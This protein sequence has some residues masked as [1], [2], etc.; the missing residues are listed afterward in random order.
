MWGYGLLGV[1]TWLMSGYYQGKN[2]L[3]RTLLIANGVLSLLSALWTIIDVN[4]VMTTRGLF[5]YFFWNLL[6]IVMMI[7]IYRYSK[8]VKE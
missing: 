7:L 4:W 5:L 2:R 1:A 6:M 3:I 8:K